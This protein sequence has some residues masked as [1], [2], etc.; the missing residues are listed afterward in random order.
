IQHPGSDEPLFGVSLFFIILAVILFGSLLSMITLL[1]MIYRGSAEH[2]FREQSALNEKS[3][4]S[5]KKLNN[6]NDPQNE[7]AHMVKK[8]DKRD[9]EQNMV[10]EL[11]SSTKKGYGMVRICKRITQDLLNQVYIN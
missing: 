3:Q 11:S 5:P 10:P 8:S 1:Y 4:T 2:L 9:E 6:N 7:E